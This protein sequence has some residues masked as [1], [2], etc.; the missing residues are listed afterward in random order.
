METK[1]P[2]NPAAEE[3]LASLRRAKHL[4]KN[5]KKTARSFLE[6]TDPI[7][8]RGLE[9]QPEETETWRSRLVSFMERAAETEDI[10]EAA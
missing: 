8:Y 10:Q 7:K 1:R 6:E 4:D 5:L 2:T 3:I 9:P